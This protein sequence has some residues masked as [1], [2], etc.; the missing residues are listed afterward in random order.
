[1]DARISPLFFISLKDGLFFK[2]VLMFFL[3]LQENLFI[4]GYLF[5]P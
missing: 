3:F 2:N 1:M 5:N 4:V